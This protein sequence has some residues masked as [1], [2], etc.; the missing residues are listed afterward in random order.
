MNKTYHSTQLTIAKTLQEL[1]PKSS[2]ILDQSTTI[3]KELGIYES[4]LY[5]GHHTMAPYLFVNA[6]AERVI[7]ATI[8]FGSLYYLDD[9]FGED[10]EHEIKADFNV[11]FDAWMTGKYEPITNY[12]PLNNLYRSIAYASK[13]IQEQSPKAYFERYTKGLQQHLYHSLHPAEY[14]TV[15]E[16]IAT[17]MH[18]GGMY[19]TIGMIEFAYDIFLEASLLETMPGLREAEDA[20]VLIGALSNDIFSY[21]K[22]AHSKYN[23]LNAYLETGEAENIDEAIEKAILL[24]NK[25]YEDFKTAYNIA[26]E[27]ADIQNNK[28]VRIYLDGLNVIVAASYHWQ[29]STNR[30][31]SV[32]NVFSD[33]KYPVEE[34]MALAF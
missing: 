24:V 18:S 13:R 6:D 9:F 28:E 22:E 20:S 33:L 10:I 14:T 31:R 29:V 3:A 5:E 30:Y 1:H 26:K 2:Y 12:A 23:L 34:R 11:L 19:P 16:Y 25:I 27:I 15:E 32:D 8:W 7:D 21:H 17:R 4:S